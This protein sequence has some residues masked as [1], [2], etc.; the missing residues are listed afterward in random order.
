MEGAVA[1]GSGNPLAH[2]QR[3]IPHRNGRQL[4][5]GVPDAVI[6][7]LILYFTG[8]VYRGFFILAFIE[9]EIIEKET[10]D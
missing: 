8:R 6:S 2:G 7:I 10:V 9:K 4:Q 3:D 5:T 1:C